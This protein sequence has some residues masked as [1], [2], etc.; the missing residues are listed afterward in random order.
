MKRNGSVANRVESRRIDSDHVEEN[1]WFKGAPRQAANGG[2]LKMRNARRVLLATTCAV[3]WSAVG[4]GPLAAQ[5]SGPVEKVVVT[6]TRIKQPNTESNA[7]I[8]TIAQQKIELSGEANIADVLREL[9]IIGVPAISSTNSNFQTSANGVNTVSLRNLGT[10]RTLVLINGRRAVAGLPLTQ[11]VDLNQ[12][13]TEMIERVDVLAGGSSAV[14]GSDAV[15]GVINVILKRNFEGVSVNVQAGA[16]QHYE[17]HDTYQATGTMGAN[18]AEGKGNAILS[19]GYSSA[20]PAYAR[21]RDPVDCLS[22]L[23]FGL[24]AFEQFCPFLSGFAEGGV[25]RFSTAAGAA[26]VNRVIDH[27]D[28]TTLRPLN[29]NGGGVLANADGFNRQSQRLHFV[30]FDRYQFTGL[31]NYE[32]VAGHNLFSEVSWSNTTSNAQIE[33]IPAATEDIFGATEQ[34]GAILG[35]RMGIAPNN[36]FVPRN[37]LDFLGTRFGIDPAIIAGPRQPLVDALMAIPGAAIG[38]QRR[39][40]ELGNR[41]QE[42]K[43]QTARFVFGAEGPIGNWDY[44]AGFIYG[45]TQQSQVGEGGGINTSNM[46]EALNAVDLNTDG[47]NDPFTNPQD[48][49]CGNPSARLEGCVPINLFLPVRTP[50]VWT[51]EQIQYIRAPIF[52]DQEQDQEILYMTFT[53]T[54]FD[55]WAGEVEAAVGA[56]YRREAGA[57]ITDALTRT[58]QNT[59]NIAPPTRGSLDVWEGFGEVQVPLLRDLPWVEELNIHGAMRVSSYSTFGYTQAWSADFEYIP[60]NGVRLRG[61]IGRSVRAPNIGELFTG[62]SENFAVVVDPCNNLRTPAGGGNTLPGHPTDPVVIANCLANPGILARAD[63]AAG[64]VLTQPELQGTGGFG[65]GNPALQP[66]TG[67]SWQVGFVATPDLWAEWLGDLTLSV[68]YFHIEISDAIAALGRNQTL[69]LCYETPGLALPFC[70]QT[71]GGPRGFVR[72]VNGAL[73]EVNVQ[74]ANQNEIESNGFDLQIFYSLELAELL[75]AE[76]DDFGRLSLSANWQHT[77]ALDTTVLAGTALAEVVAAVPSVGAFEDEWIF[78]AVYGFGDL[79][80]SW[81]GQWMSAV[82]GVDGPDDIAPEEIADQW[83]HDISARYDLTE[84]LSVYGGVRNVEDNNVFIG[85]GAFAAT[86]TGWATDPDTYD[87]LGRRYF[88]GVRVDL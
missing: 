43:S 26:S 11:I 63:T 27:V 22:G 31:L 39:W 20:A 74:A 80:L 82:K 79:T 38:F 46:R 14:Y 51:A 87:G 54:L 15:V 4:S 57:D 41:G 18:F 16:T 10:D 84:Y 55:N 6:G 62:A 69:T 44:E 34:V 66:E 67:N 19:V 33:P 28:G 50:G 21:S 40:T 59:S 1:G 37:V 76:T 88:L 71:P 29:Q 8:Q 73:V 68:D 64:F 47:D 61:Q 83:F 85:P 24:S 56:E 52:R 75:A 65:Q 81:T 70:A 35:Q 13:P 49:V 9:P 60:T 23:F 86:P 42:F 36:P 3:A 32:P 48:V 58:G 17:E 72:D 30:P 25:L 45:R 78:G 53:G 12:I 7:E 5:D 2:G 77:N